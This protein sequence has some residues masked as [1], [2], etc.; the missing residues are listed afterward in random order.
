MVKNNDKDQGFE[1]SGKHLVVDLIFGLILVG[2]YAGA[3]YYFEPFKHAER[4]GEGGKMNFEIKKAKHMEEKLSDV[5]GIDEIRDEV[6]DLIKMIK[7]TKSYTSKGAKLYRGVLLS[8][9]PGT[10]KTLLA[11]AIAGESEVNFLYCTGSNFDEMFVGMGAKRVR[12]LFAEARKNTPCIIFIDEIDSLMSKSRRFGSE[13]S[14]SRGTI[15]QLLAEMDGFEKHEDIV[16]IGATNHEQDLDPAAIRPGR[17]DKKIH[18]PLPD[19]NGRKEILQLYLD[20]ISLSDKVEAKKLATMTPGFSG[21]EIQNLVN[22]AITQAVHMHK[23]EADLADFEYARDRL[24]MG[25]ERKKLTMSEKDRLNT[26]IHEAGHATVCFFTKGA[27]K[28]Y[29]ATIVA[30]GGSLGATFMEPDEESMLST[31][32]MKCLA[33]I[34]TAM[35]GHV[36]EKLFIGDKKITTGCS[37]DLQGATDIAYQAVMK[38]GMFG[39][40]LGYM[41]S[42]TEELSEEMKAKIDDKV[43]LILQESE[44]R[45]EKLLL[46]K[47]SEIRELAKNLYWYD[48]LDADE[49]KTIFTGKGLEK[50][51]VREWEESETKH[52][53][54]QF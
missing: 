7:D 17:F 49:M 16:V 2:V 15:N 14:S 33:N 4:F 27:Q 35:G 31:T 41:S 51:R 47:G 19:V 8:G 52:G 32:K 13:H 25:I 43:K 53:M 36:A 28:L 18:V 3:W 6:Q 40:E 39:E 44:V 54:V 23:E 22:T 38:Y 50:E 11:R 42:S 21:A 45:V 10:G 12:E 9:S 20:K 24:M 34:D 30:R 37:S 1:Y 46:D 29:K 5:K 48:Y 26:A